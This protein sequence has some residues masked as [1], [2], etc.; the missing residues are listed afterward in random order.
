MVVVISDVELSEI[1]K[2][3][4][5]DQATTKRL[6]DSVRTLKKRVFHLDTQNFHNSLSSTLEEHDSIVVEIETL[7]KLIPR[8]PIEE[9]LDHFKNGGKWRTVLNYDNG[10]VLFYKEAANAQ[11]AASRIGDGA[12]N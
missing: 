11:Q 12:S 8:M 9:Q 7:K 4:S 5:L 10:T 1:E 3:T 2:S 6:I